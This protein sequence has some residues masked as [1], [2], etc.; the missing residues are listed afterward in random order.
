[1]THPTA[2][3][4]AEHP[5]AALD[6][7]RAQ[8][9]AGLGPAASPFVEQGGTLALA[10][11][12]TLATMTHRWLLPRGLPGEEDRTGGRNLEDRRLLFRREGRGLNSVTK[13]FPEGPSSDD[14][15]QTKGKEARGSLQGD[16][17]LLSLIPK[18]P[19]CAFIWCHCDGCGQAAILATCLGKPHIL[20][21]A[22]AFRGSSGSERPRCRQHR[23][24]PPPLPSRASP[25]G[26]ALA[27][28]WGPA[29]GISCTLLVVVACVSF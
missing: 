28:P 14:R 17:E 6:S 5:A 1:M 18:Y 20:P 15:P 21:R 23:A 7:M 12:V 26:L 4:K 8:A 10:D 24:A 27:T 19:K 3:Q 16:L 2:M 13:M 11:K 25:S 29:V 9:A 22:Q